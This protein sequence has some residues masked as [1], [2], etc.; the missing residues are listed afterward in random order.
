MEVGLQALGPRWLR[1]L[2]RAVGETVV[3][4]SSAGGHVHNFTTESHRHGTYDPKTG[5]VEW[6]AAC[7]G[8]WSCRRLFPE[9]R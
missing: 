4:G 6:S 3:H 2:S 8:F 9:G 1:R 5:S 7:P